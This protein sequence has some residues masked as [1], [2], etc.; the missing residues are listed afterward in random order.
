MRFKKFIDFQEEQSASDKGLMGFPVS[1]FAR[2]PS[3]GLPF[4]NLR[5]VGG[6]TPRS[7]S[8]NLNPT[9]ASMMKKSMKKN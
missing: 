9:N 2:R 7:S 1:L 3:D 4:K 8:G 5:S 6:S